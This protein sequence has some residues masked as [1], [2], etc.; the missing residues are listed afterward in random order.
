ME[1]QG[2]TVILEKT[3]LGYGLR[4]ALQ[5][6]ARISGYTSY[7]LF[8][9]IIDRLRESP[10]T[11]RDVAKSLGMEV[12]NIWHVM[13]VLVKEEV[14]KCVRFEMKG[15]GKRAVYKLMKDE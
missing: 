6:N 5:T 7:C 1:A 10:A 12:Q 11:R 15:T 2:K 3:F 14:I 8:K 9:K 13:R 4:M